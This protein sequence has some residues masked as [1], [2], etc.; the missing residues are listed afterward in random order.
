M[1]AELDGLVT[2]FASHHAIRADNVL[3]RSGLAAKLIPG[4]KDVSPNCGTAVRICLDEWAAAHMV[5]TKRKV[6]IDEVLAWVP[7][8]DSW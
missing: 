5:L 4:P 7:A 2:F 6:Q 1:S 3:R 8:S